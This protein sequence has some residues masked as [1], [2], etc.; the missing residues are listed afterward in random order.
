M[1]AQA[2]NEPM[3]NDS[4]I[5]NIGA[6]GSSPK[7]WNNREQL[8]SVRTSKEKLGGRGMAVNYLVLG[9]VGEG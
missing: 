2:I 7:T 4:I 5:A 3:A 8:S 1:L 9:Y 6:I